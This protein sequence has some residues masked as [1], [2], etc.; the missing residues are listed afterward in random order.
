MFAAQLKRLKRL[1]PMWALPGITRG[2]PLQSLPLGSGG[3]PEKGHVYKLPGDAEA[4]GLVTT[5]GH[6]LV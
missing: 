3:R 4:T 6:P 2:T 1:A 5:L